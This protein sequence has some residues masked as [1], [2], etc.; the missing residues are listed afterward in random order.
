MK[1]CLSSVLKRDMRYTM[2]LLALMHM[3]LISVCD[4]GKQRI[5]IIGGPVPGDHL[6]QREVIKR[7]WC[8]FCRARRV[9]LLG[10]GFSKITMIKVSNQAQRNNRADALLKGGGLGRTW[11]T[12]AFKS[13]INNPIHFIVET[14]GK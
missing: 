14:Y 9:T 12:F 2:I 3:I 4:A 7:D 11:V 1:T 8:W 5:V 13:H 6:L 10:D